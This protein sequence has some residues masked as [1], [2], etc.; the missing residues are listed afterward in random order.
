M[1]FMFNSLMARRWQDA[2]VG[3]T[4][5]TRENLSTATAIENG[6]L[7]YVNHTPLCC[8]TFAN[9]NINLQSTHLISEKLGK[10]GLNWKWNWWHISKQSGK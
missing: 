10:N 7:L 9:W 6:A 4:V 3:F 8:H 1:S 5:G 2:Q